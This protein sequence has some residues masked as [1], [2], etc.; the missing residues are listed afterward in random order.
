[1]GVFAFVGDRDEWTQRAAF[2]VDSHLIPHCGDGF[3]I[4]VLDLR[5]PM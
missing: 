1:M 5:P 3:T 4:H 2:D